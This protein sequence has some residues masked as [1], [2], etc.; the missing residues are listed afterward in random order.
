LQKFTSQ[1]ESFKT[2]LSALSY[3][4][5]FEV[6]DLFS[7]FHTNIPEVPIKAALALRPSCVEVFNKLKVVSIVMRLRNL[8]NH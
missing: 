3:L 8:E 2:E 6:R 5:N 7:A 1:L 4:K